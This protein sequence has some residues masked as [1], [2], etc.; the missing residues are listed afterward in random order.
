VEYAL[1]LAGNNRN[2]LEKVLEH[3][4][5]DP[6]DSL[7]Y[8]AAVFL[9]E[10]M[11]YYSYYEGKQLEN[12]SNIY[13]SILNKKDVFAVLD[14]FKNE[15][16]PFYPSDLKTKHDIQEINSDYIIQNIEWAFK[17]RNEQPWGIGLSFD[18]FC[19]YI[20]PYRVNKEQPVDWRQYL[21][22]KYN[23]L[24]DS[25]IKTNNVTDPLIAAQIVMDHLCKKDKFFTA[26]ASHIPLLN[27]LIIDRFPAGSCR[28]LA[29]LTV[30][31][32]R[33]LGIPCGIDY[34]PVHG[35]FNTPHC[36][37]FILDQN[38][39]TYTSDYL[40]CAIVP[41]LDVFHFTSKIYRE[42]FCTNQTI[43]QET[44]EYK[45]S[46][47]PFLKNPRFIDVTDLYTK[48]PLSICIPESVY[49]D[50]EKPS[51]IYLC[52]AQFQNWTPVDWTIVKENKIVFN[53]IKLENSAPVFGLSENN[54]NF[55]PGIIKD[56]ME[57]IVFR[58]AYRENNQLHYITD[59]FIFKKNGQ[60]EFMTPKKEKKSMHLFSKSNL[61]CEGF[62]QNLPNGIFEA[63]NDK[64]FNNTDTLYQIHE[65]PVRLS[66]TVWINTNNKYRYIRFKGTDNSSCSISEIQIY[67]NSDTAKLNGKPFGS[68]DGNEIGKHG[69]SNAFDGNPYTSFYSPNLSGDW[70]G[71]DLGKSYNISKIIYIPRN[72]DNFIRI[73]DRYELFYLEN[74]N[75]WQSL[76][77]KIADADS[78]VFEN[79]PS[80]AL[81]YLKNYTRGRDERIFIYKENTQVFL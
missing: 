47:A 51:I 68:I 23:P 8:K 45:N 12:Y 5:K 20:L 62:V 55:I 28:D 2:E 50:N 78:L 6:G 41:A 14:S 57:S 36:W 74:E 21:Y 25:I 54:I 73:G 1:N 38:G 27:P 17:V 72:R 67:S 77:T 40:R 39:T 56:Y 49:T 81:F 22:E 29:D 80:N 16:G 69:Y 19:N 31:I 71:I 66:N 59:P 4:S 58:V 24:L 76:G 33:A 34:F 70:V 46:V 7:K 10:N 30:Y 60:L 75:N 64:D 18:V 35:R 42:T 48:E 26:E 13:E 52:V 11:P 65:V 53:K 37:T 79:T 63:S 43:K 44:A 9:I 32:L 3:Y 61:L 15:Y